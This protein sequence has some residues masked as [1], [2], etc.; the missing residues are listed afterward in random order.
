MATP[1]GKPETAFSMPTAIPITPWGIPRA[2]Q[3][4]NDWG[5]S[6]GGPIWKS[7]LFF[8]VNFEGVSQKFSGLPTTEFPTSQAQQGNF[9][10]NGTDG[11]THTVNLLTLAAGNGLP[12]TVNPLITGMLSA[13]NGYAKNG[14]ISPVSGLPYEQS[15][16][17][18]AI[19]PDKERYPTVRFDF[20]ITPKV[21]WHGSWDMWWRDISNGPV[22]YPG[23]MPSERFQ[24]DLLRCLEWGGLDDL[25][26]PYQPGQLWHPEQ[27]RIVQPGKRFQFVS[28]PRQLRDQCGCSRELRAWGFR[29][30]DSGLRSPLP[31]NNP[32]WTFY[33]N[34]SWTRGKH[35]FTFGGDLRISNSHELEINNPPAENLGLS[36]LD[37]ALAMFSA[38]NFP[39]ISS[40]KRKS[41]SVERSGP[42]RHTGGAHQLHFRLQLGGHNHAPVSDSGQGD[43]LGE[44]NR[45]RHLFPG[46]LAHH[47]PLC[48][49]LWLPLAV[50]WGR[51]QHQRPLDWSYPRRPLW[52]LYWAVPA[53]H[54]EWKSQSA[55]Q[56]P[57]QPLQRRL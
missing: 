24:V 28:G 13:I 55:N 45:R 29:P 3:V 43:E 26:T 4:L 11:N 27:R 39:N 21:A 35:T 31:R 44:A 32:V 42:L 1:S 50:L 54:V 53:G 19:Q 57:A 8:F 40:A 18:T 33:D 52:S 48:S 22:N 25:A 6:L 51:P 2:F 20:Q 14:A 9:I 34:L 15:V 47:A 23:A 12:S 49:E 41:G 5:G 16:S 17:F 7:K 38:A 46:F 37:P 56:S 36:S 30:G 10:Y